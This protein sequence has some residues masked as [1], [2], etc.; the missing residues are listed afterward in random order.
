MIRHGRQRL[1]CIIDLRRNPGFGFNFDF[2][3]ESSHVLD[4]TESRLSVGWETSIFKTGLGPV[5]SSAVPSNACACGVD[6]LILGLEKVSFLD[7]EVSKGDFETVGLDDAVPVCELF[8]DI[9][10]HPQRQFG[11]EV[12]LFVVKPEDSPVLAS[13]RESD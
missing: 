13:S 6:L 8:Q 7:S 9:V 1:G 4:L 2:T 12:T 10:G 11:G 5:N 3:L